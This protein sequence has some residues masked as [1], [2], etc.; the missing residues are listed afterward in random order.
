MRYII[1]WN[2]FSSVQNAEWVME[3]SN[4]WANEWLTDALQ[5]YLRRLLMLLSSSWL[6][7]LEIGFITSYSSEVRWSEA[8]VCVINAKGVEV[9]RARQAPKHRGVR[10][11]ENPNH[12]PMY[13]K[14]RGRGNLTWSAMIHGNRSRNRVLC[15]FVNSMWKIFVKWKN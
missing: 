12:D 15:R 2:N 6:W 9:R 13:H 7:S 8:A 14:I 5:S 11:E 3:K 4:E 10:S 1:M